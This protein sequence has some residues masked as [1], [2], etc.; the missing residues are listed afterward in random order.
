V[1]V[2]KLAQVSDPAQKLGLLVEDVPGVDE[3]DGQIDL[4]L[5]KIC[6]VHAKFRQ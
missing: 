1:L 2:E 3:A 5:L 4:A 6:S